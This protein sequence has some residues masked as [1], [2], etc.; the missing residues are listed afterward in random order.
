MVLA[1]TR[2]AAARGALLLLIADEPR[3][4]LDQVHGVGEVDRRLNADNEE[5]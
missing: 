5:P 1:L 4:P 2:A 3:D